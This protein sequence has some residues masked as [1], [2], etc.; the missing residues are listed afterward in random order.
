MASGLYSKTFADLMTQDNTVDFNLAQFS[1]MLVTS[2]YTPLFDTHTGK[3]D[4]QTYEVTSGGSTNYTAGG[5]ALTTVTLTRTS[6][7]TSV[8]TWDADNVSWTSS[9]IS[10]A[11][12]G[13]I[14]DNTNSGLPLIGFIDFAGSFSTTSGTFEVQ[15]NPSGI[16]TFDLTPTPQEIWMPTSNYPTSLDTT[17]TQVTPT[18]STD[19]DATGYEHDLVHGAASTALIALQTKLGIS[20]SP[21]ASAT[22]GYF[23]KHTGTGTTDWAAVPEGTSVIEVQVFS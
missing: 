2:S 8:I 23:L 15:W 19:L 5:K 20:A 1:L 13:V 7:N 9:T 10:S 12:G 14:Y 3:S 21:A 18:S 4:A 22:A 6:D 16:F 17:A 11:A